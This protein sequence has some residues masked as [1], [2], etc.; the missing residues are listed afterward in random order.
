M[1]FRSLAN[2]GTGADYYDSALPTDTRLT[3]GNTTN[4]YNINLMGTSNASA[5]ILSTVQL[6]QQLQGTAIA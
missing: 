1:N 6:L 4:T 2:Y 5:D 3:G